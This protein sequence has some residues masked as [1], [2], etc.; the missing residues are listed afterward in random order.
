MAPERS[1]PNKRTALAAGTRKPSERVK[2]LV[3]KAADT[4][5]E[6]AKAVPA[7]ANTKK[8]RAATTTSKKPAAK[9]VAAGRVV[10]PA[11]KAAP[12]KK[13][14]PMKKPAPARKAAPAKKASPAKKAAPAKKTTA[15]KIKKASPVKKPSPAKKPAA[16]ASKKKLISPNSPP[17]SPPKKAAAPAPVFNTDDLPDYE[18]EEDY[19]PPQAASTDPR[20]NKKGN[21][22]TLQSVAKMASGAVGGVVEAGQGLLRGMSPGV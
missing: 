9:K 1:S 3:K 19:E 5:K 8:K 7:E 2:T 15:P 20:L 11:K 10:K 18:D 17:K 4:A 6:V 13:A 21:D 16:A 14:A 12:V 22:S